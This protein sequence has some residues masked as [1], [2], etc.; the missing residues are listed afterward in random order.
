MKSKIFTSDPDLQ[1]VVTRLIKGSDCPQVDLIHW[2]YEAP[3]PEERIAR[4]RAGIAAWEV[5]LRR[6]QK[7]A[8]RKHWA[9]DGVCYSYT[10]PDYRADLGEI[11][12][13]AE[14]EEQA[15]VEHSSHDEASTQAEP[16]AMPRLQPS[17]RESLG[18]QRTS[19]NQKQPEQ[20]SAAECRLVIIGR[21]VSAPAGGVPQERDY[22]AVVVWL[23][24]ERAEGTDWYALA[25]CNRSRMCRQLSDRLGWE[26]S[27]NSLRKAQA[28]R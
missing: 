16:A 27:E 7:P 14:R 3:S 2:A 26:V 21:A 22:A 15:E 25:G 18:E 6:R 23:E 20:G 5:L 8:C 1:E 4:A 9:D 19:K 10:W 17:N 13:A 24:K 28:R 12:D 11:I